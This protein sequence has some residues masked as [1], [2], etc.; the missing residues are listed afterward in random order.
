MMSEVQ[1]CK[2]LGTLA[3]EA[4]TTYLIFEVQGKLFIVDL[5]VLGPSLLQN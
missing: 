4:L 5:S 3:L 1:L 2:Y